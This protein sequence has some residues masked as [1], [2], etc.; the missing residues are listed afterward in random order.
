MSSLPA[1]LPE[2][3]SKAIGLNNVLEVGAIW[4]VGIDDLGF[5]LSTLD[6]ESP[7]EYRSYELQSIPALNPRVDQSSEHG[8][9]TLSPWWARAQH[10]WHLGAG[11]DVLD[12]ENSTRFK[13]KTSKGINPWTEGQAT[14]LKDVAELRNDAT[15]DHH[16]IST[17]LALIYTYNG[18]IKKDPDPDDTAEAGEATEVTHSG[19]PINS[20]TSDG[21]SVYVAF[22]GGTLGIRK[23][24]ISTFAAWVLVNAQTAVDV[25]AFVKGR[26]MGAKGASVY[27]YDLSLTT[28]P[29]PF[30]TDPTGNWKWTAIT[31][32]GPAIYF[33]GFAGDRSEIYAARLTAQDIPYASLATVGAMRSVWQAPEGETIHTIKGYIGQQVLIGTSRGVR[34]GTI[35]TGD[36]DLSVSELIAETPAAVLSFEPQQEFA[37]FTW[38]NYDAS[39]AGLGRIHLGDLA[40][41]SDLMWTTQATVKEV[42]QYKNRMYFVADEGVTS[43]IIKEHATNLVA[44]A[45]LN[46]GEIRFGTS[47]RKN[48]RYFDILSKATGK[49]SLHIGL[50]GG[51]LVAFSTDIDAGGYKSEVITLEGSH[52]EQQITLKRDA[53]DA[54]K[55]PTLLEWRLRAEAKT[56]GRFRF[57]VPVMCYDYM[58]NQAGREVGYEGMAFDMMN[59]LKLLYRNDTDINFSPLETGV[60]DAVSPLTVTMEDVRFKSFTPPKGGKGFGGIALVVLREVR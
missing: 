48:I 1:L 23:I 45:T 33:S 12:A 44:S 49:W 31:E 50:D 56:T 13:F 9:Q 22:S 53:A 47:E 54:T 4:D 37:W 18:T 19:T 3:L 46:V 20:L 57:L 38:T 41:A 58:V 59:H 40:Y 30:Y 17:D 8:E 6:Q 24:N 35:V 2:D 51:A 55:G 60:P 21:E 29:A 11:Q 14:L 39:S 10:S 42:V 36:G 28:E 26:L 7:F 16:L 27:E 25:I 52:I 34:I 15:D 43:R 32:A 5:M